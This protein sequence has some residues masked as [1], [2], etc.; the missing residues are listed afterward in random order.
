MLLES[1]CRTDD[2][3]KP[4]PDITITAN[5]AAGKTT[6]IIEFTVSTMAGKPYGN[7][8]FYRW[9][10][11]DD[12][13]WET[14]FSSSPVTKHRYYQKGDQV[15]HLEVSD[16]K[17]QVRSFSLS[18]KVLQ[19]FSPPDA[20]FV[21]S[22]PAG[23]PTV[24]FTFDASGTHDDEDSLSQ[25]QFRWDPVGDGRWLIQ[26]SSNP[27]AKYKYPRAGFY[28]PML[29]VKDPSGRVATYSKELSV[30][31]ID[32]LIFASF[33]I[34]PDS[35]EVNQ[36]II[37][38]ASLS[39]YPPDTLQPLLFSWLLPGTETWTEPV[40]DQKISH[41]FKQK[42]L[43]KITLKVT[44]PAT[45]FY[46]T[47]TKEILIADENLPP[48]ARF[49]VA[50]A[51]GNVLT[52][53]FFDAWSSSDDRLPPSEIDIRWDFN[54]DGI[55]DTPFSKKKYLYHQYSQAGQYNAI[56]QV[57]D[58]ENQQTQ[59]QL[60]ITVSN[61][62]NPTSF[63]RDTRDARY[64]G[65]VKIGNQW[66][67]SENMN[68]SIPKKQI[69]KGTFNQWNCL[70]E[71][72]TQ[73]EQFGKMYFVSGVIENRGDDEFVK[74]CPTGWRLPSKQDWELL[75]NAIGGEQ[76][77]KELRLDGK[78]DFN[79]LDLGYGNY[80]FVYK[81]GVIIP[82]D[83]IYSFKET[84]QK[85]WFFSTTEAADPQNLRMDVWMMNLDRATGS[86]WSGFTLPDVY[87]PARCVKNE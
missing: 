36:A 5:P 70:F 75:F 23:N 78:F 80:T 82:V 46:N 61:N 42:G 67:M 37:L 76:N 38:D 41:I 18:L 1:G 15:I 65:T 64:Y 59:A 86:T 11:N 49:E 29:Q 68:F 39:R 55:W 62:T 43:G 87:V 57:R 60:K 19:G 50:C 69:G 72:S 25:L 58:D 73:C 4:I 17:K 77:A 83:T 32:T 85:S 16:G 52:Q 71:Q 22:P 47:I 44:N 81:D 12:G 45:D 3:I 63:F 51:N 35:I 28:K 53:F 54:G 24:E 84:Y 14:R 10:W 20:I 33:T 48:N 2:T 7:S 26:Y 21:I 27:V 6:D 56:L 8:L 66:W 34:S 79:A 13:I 9:D 74:I 40:K 31:L 30:N